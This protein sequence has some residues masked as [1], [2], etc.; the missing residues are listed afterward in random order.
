MILADQVRL[1]H[2]TAYTLGMCQLAMARKALGGSDDVVRDLTKQWAEGLC[3][4]MGVEVEAHGMD[5]VDWSAPYV[6]MANHQSYLDVLALYRAL[7]RPF[8]IVAK[9]SLFGV[10]FFGGVM[11][12]L[13]CVSVDRSRH[14]EA[15]RAMSDAGETMRRTRVSIAVFPE[16]TRSPGDRV[17]KLKKGPFHL[18][19]HAGVPVLPIGIRGTSALMPK[20]NTA[21][22]SGKVEVHVG[23]P[24]AAISSGDAAARERLRREVREALGRLAALPLRG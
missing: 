22:R 15:A 12:A 6:V 11:R 2:A 16:G 24:I 23:Q 14:V 10:P 20:S 3:A 13:G 17:A 4:R 7:P 1:A 19:Q 9:R 21:I 5:E 8:G 18:A